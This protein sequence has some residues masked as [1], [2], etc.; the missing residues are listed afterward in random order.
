MKTKRFAT[1]CFVAILALSVM[2]TMA[3]ATGHPA[4]EETGNNLSFPVIAVDGFIITPLL[5]L[6]F[7]PCPMPATISD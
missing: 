2:T 7:S 1:S 4:V 6:F 3:I 5:Q